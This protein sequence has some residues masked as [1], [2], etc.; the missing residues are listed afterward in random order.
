MSEP[1]APEGTPERWVVTVTRLD[2]RRGTLMLPYRLSGRF[3]PGILTCEDAAT[4]ETHEV[5]VQDERTIDGLGPVFEAHDVQVNDRIV[6]HVLDGPSLRVGFEKRARAPRQNVQPSRWY[7]VHD[8]APTVQVTAGE[9]SPSDI[10]GA[11]TPDASE[12]AAV[13]PPESVAPHAEGPS[14]F[15]DTWLVDDVAVVDAEPGQGHVQTDEPTGLVDRP[16]TAAAVPAATP[17]VQ[18]VEATVDGADATLDPFEDDY[19]PPS[20]PKIVRDRPPAEGS[21]RDPFA[22]FTERDDDPGPL[23]RLGRFTRSL[24]AGNPS[25]LE[26][27]TTA[28]E[29]NATTAD[30]AAAPD[31]T[32]SVPAPASTHDAS[33]RGPNQAAWQP[34]SPL[35]QDD[36]D[37]GSLGFDMP[38]ESRP[39]PGPSAQAVTDATASD[40][41][42][43]DV[44]ESDTGDPVQSFAAATPETPA[45]LGLDAPA[46][47]TPEASAERA[48]ADVGQADDV[49]AGAGAADEHPA[50]QHPASNEQADDEGLFP[51]TEP[52]NATQPDAPQPPIDTAAQPSEEGVRQGE[53]VPSWLEPWRDSQ[54]DDAEPETPQADGTPEPE[55]APADPPATNEPQAIHSDAEAVLPSGVPVPNRSRSDAGDLRTRISRFLES[56]DMPMIARTDVVA[57]SFSLDAETAQSMLEDLAE[58]PP[59]GLRLILVRDGAWR[60]ERTGV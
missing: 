27:D 15:D 34:A 50:D 18:S 45:S 24:F 23:E 58:S 22:A 49:T 40:A 10:P 29:P 44:T 1:T 46:A 8:D 20:A 37:D 42:A 31:T 52:I 13:L 47:D 14:E 25:N 6:L 30:A 35:W 4:G 43:S 38:L 17:N 33:E 28:E 3:Q 16:P 7:S 41:N 51:E 26:V 36:E 12:N 53:T 19:N 56:P 9:A 57:K 21:E 59:Q 60:I 55:G 2:L 32:P 11:T 54:Q 48:P 5:T 39:V